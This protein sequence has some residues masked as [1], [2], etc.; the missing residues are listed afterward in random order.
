MLSVKTAS[1]ELRS[2]SPHWPKVHRWNPDR[3]TFTSPVARESRYFWITGEPS[4]ATCACNTVRDR[5]YGVRITG[6]GTDEMHTRCHRTVDS[7]LVS[8]HHDVPAQSTHPHI[9]TR[10]KNTLTCE[11][12][13]SSA[14]RLLT[15]PATMRS[16]ISG[17]F[18]SS[19]VC[20]L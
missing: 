10:T 5:E 6:H 14:M 13:Q 12:R 16:S 15:L 3:D 2:L 17:F 20:S 1:R 9:T 19:T 4:T 8:K 7:P 18:L 11:T